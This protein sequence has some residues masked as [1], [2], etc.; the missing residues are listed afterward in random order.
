[1]TVQR[2]MKMAHVA[3]KRLGIDILFLTRSGGWLMLG[4]F[5]QS[6][7]VIATATLFARFLAP[8]T[9]GI[10]KYLL[11]LGE[12][13][14][15]A[16]LSGA[17]VAL[18]RDLSRGREAAAREVLRLWRLSF[19]GQAAVALAFAG[20]YWAHSNTLFALGVLIAAAGQGAIMWLSRP[21]YILIVKER[22]DLLTYGSATVPLAQ[23]L[24]VAS[25]LLLSHEEPS[26]LFLLAA[27]LTAGAAAAG[28]FLFVVSRRLDLFPKPNPDKPHPSWRELF[29]SLTSLSLS[30]T[31]GSVMP[32]VEA[33]LSF[34]L[35]GP[36]AL[37][38]YSFATAIPRQFSFFSKSLEQMQ[39]ARS[40]AHTLEAK[41]AAFPRKWWLAFAGSCAIVGAYWVAAPFIF[42][43]LFPQYIS[44]LPLSQWFALAYAFV[45]P[46]SA[47]YTLLVQG[48]KER[49]LPYLWGLILAVFVVSASIL[50][51]QLGISGVLIASVLGYAT[52]ALAGVVSLL[53][54]LRHTKATP[55][56]G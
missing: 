20:W 17:G 8:E 44:V 4:K 24:A 45:I 6:L 43:L 5:A 47:A 53:F 28:A 21:F 11:T 50:A 3:S 55:R 37:A 10:Y 19:L 51:P 2:I 15:L 9:Y 29:P 32:R 16:T 49:C 33:F 39:L 1:M 36:A 25:V 46:S 52:Y 34:Q 42:S 48:G 12:I 27:Y 31:L 18:M 56:Q 40:G 54:I 22:F 35:L 23:A 38:A 13:T 7:A 30:Q 41:F 14:L 26:P